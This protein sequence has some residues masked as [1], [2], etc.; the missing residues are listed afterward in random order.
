MKGET[1]TD[2]EAE[3]KAH[4]PQT[5]A[6]RHAEAADPLRPILIDLGRRSKKSIKAL[7]RGEGKLVDEVESALEDARASLGG[8]YQGELLPVLV[9]IRQKE[10]S[11]SGI[12]PFPSPFSLL[13]K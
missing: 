1:P 12:L 11:D 4:Q 9:I 13:G 7:R 5:A 10:D 8:K 2:K 3:P 6:Q